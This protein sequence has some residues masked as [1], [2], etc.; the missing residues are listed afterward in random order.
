MGLT[1]NQVCPLGT[2]GSNPCLSAK[3]NVLRLLCVRHEMLRLVEAGDE[4]GV[5]RGAQEA[6]YAAMCDVDE[7]PRWQAEY[8]AR[9]GIDHG[10]VTE[11]GHTPVGVVGDDGLH[12]VD[13]AHTEQ[14]EVRLVAEV[15]QGGLCGRVVLRLDAAWSIALGWYS[16]TPS[17]TTAS[18]ARASAS[19]AAVSTARR[20]GLA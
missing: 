17:H 19:G 2:Q 16:T 18:R 5:A 14:L 8:R 15:R 12:G 1:R 3:I 13:D 20:N 4:A 10:G 6:A 9:P 11:H 7:R